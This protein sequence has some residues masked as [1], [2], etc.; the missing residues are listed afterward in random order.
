MKK[1]LIVLAVTVAML[2]LTA[3]SKNEDVSEGPV[4]INEITAN[5]YCDGTTLVYSKAY[6][7]AVIPDSPECKPE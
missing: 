4:F 5:K 1:I 2:S 6:A 7:I 3:C